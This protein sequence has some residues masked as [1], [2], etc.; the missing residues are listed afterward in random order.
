MTQVDQSKSDMMSAQE[1]GV[2]T[3]KSDEQRTEFIDP[4]KRTFVGKAPFVDLG[5][6]QAFAP[7][8]RSFAVPL[9]LGDV[10]DRAVIETYLACLERIE[11][12]I[13]VEERACDSQSQPLHAF[14]GRLE[15]DL[16]VER[17]VVIARHD[18]R[19]SDYVTVRIHDGQDVT[20]LGALASLIS[21]ALAAFLGNR[22]T[23]IQV[24][25]AQIKVGLDRLNTRLPHPFQTAVATPLLKVVVDCLPTDFF[26]VA[27][28][29][30]G[31]VGTCFH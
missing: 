29:G 27:S 23:A 9:V 11:R 20:G 1:V 6:E 5:V 15:M 14:E 26:F 19:G 2:F 17:V 24:Q 25:L 30:S 10:R 13:G 8:F 16:Q 7:A 22:M 18:P 4:G 12:A 3:V 28:V 31:A 21:D